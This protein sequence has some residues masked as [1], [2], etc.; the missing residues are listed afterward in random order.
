M[1]FSKNKLLYFK[2]L[3]EVDIQYYFTKKNC[4]SNLKITLD[5]KQNQLSS[6]NLSCSKTRSLN[7]INNIHYNMVGHS[8]K[9]LQDLDKKTVET[10]EIIRDKIKDI[11][12]IKHLKKMILNF[13]KCELKKF[14]SNTV[15]SDGNNNAKIMLIGEAPGANEDKYGIP[16]CG[17]SGKLLDQMLSSIN[18]TR[19]KNA[20]IT[21]T[22]FWRPPGNRKPS[23]SETEITKPF[24]EKHISLIDPKLLIFVG[25][26]A[27]NT[28]MQ[29]N[30]PISKIQGN[31]YSY[32]NRYLKKSICTTIIY[33]PSYLLR[34]PIKKKETWFTLIK[35]KEF[36]QKHNI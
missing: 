14:A 13:D 21:N 19:S 30:D 26:T 34:N 18:I 15:F 6:G 17:E 31:F 35:I 36:I 33:H 23:R 32:N 8:E 22:I 5:K 9:E 20:Y 4:L 2:F 29:T 16:F 25:S 10:I 12:D 27:T 28:L 3:K 11:S 24:V 1:N 7:T